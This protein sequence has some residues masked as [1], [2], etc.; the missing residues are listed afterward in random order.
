MYYR[1]RGGNEAWLQARSLYEQRAA[2]VLLILS[3]KGTQSFQQLEAETGWS[4]ATV[5]TVTKRLLTEGSIHQVNIPRDTPGRPE[6]G[7][8]LPPVEA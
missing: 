5:G 8:K 3:R 2:Q 1:L 6:V 7:F 4:Y